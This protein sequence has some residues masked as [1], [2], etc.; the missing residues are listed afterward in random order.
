MRKRQTVIWLQRAQ[1][2]AD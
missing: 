1:K 2:V